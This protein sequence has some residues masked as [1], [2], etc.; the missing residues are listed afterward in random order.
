VL[1]TVEA[2][3]LTPVGLRSL[4]PRHPEYQPHY[5]GGPAARDGAYHQGTVWSWLLGPFATALVRLRGDEGRRQVRRLLEQAAGHLADGCVGSVSEIFDAEAPFTPRGCP[6]QA[7]GVAEWLR[8]AIEEASL[9]HAE[10]GTSGGASAAKS[11][12]GSAGGA[13]S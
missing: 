1:A 6:A 10:I 4:D 9:A 3:L 5:W 2:R 8:A 7:W 12:V 11:A 13:T